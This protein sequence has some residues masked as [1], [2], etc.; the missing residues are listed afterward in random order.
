MNPIKYISTGIKFIIKTAYSIIY[1][2]IYGAFIAITIIPKYFLIGLSCI[3]NGKKQK[4]LK[5]EDKIIPSIIITL[6]LTTYLLSIFLLTRWYVQNE[7]NKKFA[8]DLEKQSEIL[9]QNEPKQNTSSNYQKLINGNTSNPNYSNDLSYLNVNLNYY[10]KI[11]SQTVAWI[12]VNG[13]NINYPVV[14][15]NNNSYYL[16]HDFYKRKTSIGWVF[17]DYRDNF[18]PYNSNTIIY[19]HN[20]INRTMFGQLPYLL[21]E[22]WQSN[23]NN[24]YIKLST[25]KTNTIWQIFSVYKTE[26][27]TNYLQ[28]NFYSE[29]TY[30]NFLNSI[31]K[32][33]SYNFQTD[34]TTQ[35][36][37]ITLSTCDDTGKKRIAVHAKLIKME[38]K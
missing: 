33:S 31:K 5:L 18:D 38:T 8:N 13:T 6:S 16:S 26:P 27:T 37:I 35:D 12:K 19:A 2:L 17:A 9:S 21:K 4:K 10:K 23:P 1:H 20:L 15:T 29:Q 36:K 3:F 28:S 7:R 24:H 25:Y 32:K 30:E 14:Q 34:I 11:N 22:K